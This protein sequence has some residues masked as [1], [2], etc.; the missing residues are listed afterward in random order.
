MNVALAIFT[1]GATTLIFGTMIGLFF[2]IAC[3]HVRDQRLRHTGQ[4]ATAIVLEQSDPSWALCGK[5]RI[6][7]M[8]DVLPVG[9]APFQATFRSVV[10][11]NEYHQLGPGAAI[12]VRFNP[13]T[14][15]QLLLEQV[16]SPAF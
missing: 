1:W 8:V 14:H 11:A 6:T 4:L 5:R 16:S 2:H 12:L 13:Q 7:L 10:S 15:A 3:H 9:Q